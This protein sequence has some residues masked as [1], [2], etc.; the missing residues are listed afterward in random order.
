[1]PNGE[2]DNKVFI[3]TAVEIVTEKKICK[4]GPENGYTCENEYEEIPG[5][6]CATGSYMC[7]TRG[8]RKNQFYFVADTRNFEIQFTS[9]YEQ[10]DQRGTSLDHPAYYMLCESRLRAANETHH[11]RQ[12]L[13]HNADS[14]DECDSKTAPRVRIPCAP[15]IPCRDARDFDFLHDTGA[16]KA[17]DD[18]QRTLES[19]HPA[20]AKQ[21]RLLRHTSGSRLAA[22][23]ADAVA[24]SADV[25]ADLAD[26]AADPADA[27]FFYKLSEQ[28]V[29]DSAA[30]GPDGKQQWTSAYGDVFKLDRLMQLAG[31]DLDLNYNMNIW[32]T[33]ESG[34]VLEVSIVYYNLHPFISTFGYKEV[35]YFY[36]VKEL[37]L[38]YVSRRV[39]SIEQPADYPETRQYE[40][41]HGVLVWFKVE[42]QFGNFSQTYLLIY[43]VTTF[44]LIGAANSITDFIAVYVHSRKS[45]YFNLKYEISGD[46][47]TKWQCAKCGYW[48]SQL[49]EQ[50][51]GYEMWKNAAEAPHCGAAKPPTEVG[52]PQP[53]SLDQPG[54]VTENLSSVRSP[55]SLDQPGVVTEHLSSVRRPINLDQPGVVTEDLSSVGSDR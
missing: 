2:V 9:S 49:D 24:D 12:R 7:S 42:G 25:A 55:I 19:L 41:R 20:R 5:S 52:T 46:F 15:G 34:T 26:A 23:P 18:S 6:D 33:R 40:V 14:E 10:G 31:T 53:I 22:D 50:C 30:G 54:I 47:S 45:N 1:M 29:S 44:A 17:L 21:L 36:K 4:P 48:N 8:D 39:L 38:P 43:L 37:P 27:A 16:K 32:T 3:P 35:G 51:Q 13:R 11:W 28:P